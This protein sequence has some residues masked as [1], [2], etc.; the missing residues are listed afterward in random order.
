VQI[1]ARASASVAAQSPRLVS[2]IKSPDRLLQIAKMGH[3]TRAGSQGMRNARQSI[4]AD[5]AR[6]KKCIKDGLAL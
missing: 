1:A 2:L 5:D 6:W 4:K 3:S